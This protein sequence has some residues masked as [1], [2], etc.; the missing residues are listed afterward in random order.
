MRQ[1]A[2][3]TT[4]M[5]AVN[6]LKMQFERLST[7]VDSETPTLVS[8]PDRSRNPKPVDKLEP[9]Q[10][11][12]VVSK[13][14]LKQIGKTINSATC[15]PSEKRI[16]KT[17]QS[18]SVEVPVESAAVAVLADVINSSPKSS[19]GGRTPLTKSA[20]FDDT[21]SSLSASHTDTGPNG[22]IL[23]RIRV[24]STEEREMKGHSAPLPLV[25][26]KPKA[27]VLSTTSPKLKPKLAPKP[28]LAAKPTP[29]PK[30]SLPPK[31][32]IIPNKKNPPNPS[33]IC[34]DAAVPKVSTPEQISN[35][36]NETIPE[37]SSVG[38]IKP[39][40]PPPIAV[41]DDISDVSLP[42]EVASDDSNVSPLS[43][44]VQDLS[45]SDTVVSTPPLLQNNDEDECAT[46]H[47]QSSATATPND[48]VGSCKRNAVDSG[49]QEGTTEEHKWDANKVCD[50]VCKTTHYNYGTHT[51]LVY[52]GW[53][54]PHFSQSCI[55]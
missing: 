5:A 17:C 50:F 42:H 21:T 51:C 19:S 47:V 23:L 29:S 13:R 52:V 25:Q 32:K 31:P 30:P 46:I 26:L 3:E 7:T 44:L 37:M 53:S 16:S 43:K 4:E 38:T 6:S 28:L 54:V 18:K 8:S 34:T 35:E 10:S 2:N 12:T 27:H 40:T 22:E 36:T 20:D 1:S 9:K 55:F 48:E 33:L 39:T 11:P 45:L 49:Y 14:Q 24:N 41:N 15:N